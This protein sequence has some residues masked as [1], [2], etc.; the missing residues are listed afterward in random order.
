MYLFYLFPTFII[1]LLIN[2]SK[3]AKYEITNQLYIS[4]LLH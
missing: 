1:L 2:I 3:F 4:V